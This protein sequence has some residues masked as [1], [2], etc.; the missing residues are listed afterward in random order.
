MSSLVC[1]VV[2]FV[3]F[4]SPFVAGAACPEGEEIKRPKIGLV[5]GGGGARG[6]AHIGVIK[7]LEELNIP[8][9]YVAGTSMGSLV[10]AL[11]ATGMNADELDRT[12][13]SLEWA[14]L[15][16]D[17]VRRTD[18]PFRRKR[19]DDLSLFGPKFG[20][21]RDSTLLPR[22]AISGQKISFLFESLV[23]DRVQ[24]DDFD[25]LP[26]PFR[27]VA[28]DIA[29][30][31]VVVLDS[32]NLALAMRSSMSVPGVFDPVE[33]NG[34]LLVDGG[35]VNNVPVDVVRTMG[36]DRLIV[37][38]V[39]SPLTPRDELNNLLSVLGQMTGM[40]IRNNVEA[41]LATLKQ[42]DLLIR[43]D[44]VNV[45]STDF[46]K[47]SQA[48]DIGYRAADELSESL[49]SFSVSTAE[50]Q[51][52]RLRIESCTASS[53]VIQFVR[54]NN[55]SRFSD[56][57][58]LARL[59]IEEGQP[60]NVDLLEEDIQQI[61]ALG[62]LELVRYEVITENG[63]TGV[64]V[65]VTQDARGTAFAQLGL[66]YSG[67]QRNSQL[68][69]RLSY[70]K[71]DLDELGSELRVLTQFGNDPG[72]MTE[73]YKPLST[74]RRWIINPK[75]FASRS[76]V[77]T[78]D[79][80]GNALQTFQIDEVGG[81]ARLMREIGNYAAVFVGV[82]R[83]SGAV[84]IETG[85]PTFRN[86]NF[87]DGGF[88]AGIQWDRMDDFYLPYSG[89]FV[90]AR[91]SW[92]DE[93]LGADLEYEQVRVDA[94]IAKSFGRHTVIGLAR[95]ATTLDNDAPVYRLFRAGGFARL[96]GFNDDELVGQH[97]AMGLLSHRYEIGRN[98]F[99]PAYVGTSIEY[100]NVADFRNELFDDAVF[101]GSAYLGYRSPI[102]PLNVG[103][104]FIE[105]GRERFFVRIGNVFG[106]GNI[107]R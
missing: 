81:S 29:T 68:N 50:H 10:G 53:N 105:G 74:Q 89:V 31:R 8:V 96:T 77:T 27:A 67:D 63:Q 18:R 84:D 7:R 20:V 70:L 100:G 93:R 86:V 2:F 21:G 104:G 98:G 23:H 37:V 16:N 56:S 48:I 83:A 43:P 35:I 38:D 60:L 51:A 106:R 42:G 9:D 61:Y 59:R 45:T 26:V 15:F 73:I 54:L 33:L 65:H 91:Y 99:W 41:Q 24:V 103:Y 69:V 71:T 64:V 11:Y 49:A 55:Q 12:I 72:L 1:W 4:S 14:D 87:N 36:A 57:L 40:L 107:A 82:E 88:L 6:A 47:S 25:D 58:I 39:G 13:R 101:S 94:G 22:G 30:G 90:D 28:A 76:D 80:S 19:D 3:V 44:L 5:L 75:L 32:G 46:A 102:G 66:D 62:F 97:F 17:N 85:D 92:S 79:S 95:Y 78:Y 52:H 34:H